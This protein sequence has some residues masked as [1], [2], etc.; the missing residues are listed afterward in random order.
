MASSPDAD[1]SI[2]A[3]FVDASPL[4]SGWMFQVLASGLVVDNMMAANTD[5][6]ERTIFIIILY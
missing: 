4:P 6:I 1:E 5:K 3:W 2:P